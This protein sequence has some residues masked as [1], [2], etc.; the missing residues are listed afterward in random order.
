MVRAHWLCSPVDCANC[1]MCRNTVRMRTQATALEAFEDADKNL[2]GELS[3]VR[4]ARVCVGVCVYGWL[5]ALTRAVCALSCVWLCR[6]AEFEQWYQH[7]PVIGIPLSD[8]R[9]RMQAQRE[10]DEEMAAS[11]A[12]LDDIRK[13]IRFDQLSMAD[14]LRTFEHHADAD[15]N[16]SLPAF[17]RCVL[18]LTGKKDAGV[19]VCGCADIWGLR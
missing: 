12:Y 13:V 4:R 19:R 14:V 1:H 11:I 6:F 9:K 16:I 7:D 15:G 8:S 3:Y 18:L 17:K 2:D 5:L 10:S